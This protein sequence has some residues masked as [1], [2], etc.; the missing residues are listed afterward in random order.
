MA[1]LFINEGNENKADFIKIFGTDTLPIKSIIPSEI[2]ILLSKEKVSVYF[3]DFKK[4]T[5]EQKQKLYNYL[6]EKHGVSKKI[7]EQDLSTKGFP[8]LAKNTIASIPLSFF[9]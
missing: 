8:I 2:T 6:S 5:P 1:E 7:I 4:I 9:L 3:L